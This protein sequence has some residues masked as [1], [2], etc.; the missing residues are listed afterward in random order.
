MAM[1]RH[2]LHEPMAVAATA[3]TRCAPL[4]SIRLQAERC[5]N[6]CRRSQRDTNSLALNGLLEDG[7]DSS[8]HHRLQASRVA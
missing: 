7:H 8:A 6:F 5:L 4:A 2:S 1:T 3:A